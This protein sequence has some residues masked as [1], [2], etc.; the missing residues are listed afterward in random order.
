MTTPTTFY[1]SHN[2]VHKKGELEY[3]CFLDSYQFHGLPELVDKFENLYE[4]YKRETSTNSKNIIIENLIQVYSKIKRKIIL[5]RADVT[6]KTCNTQNYDSLDRLNDLTIFHK[7]GNEYVLYDNEMN[8]ALYLLHFPQNDYKSMTKLFGER[9][10]QKATS[11]V[12]A[13]NVQ[14][15]NTD[16]QNGEVYTEPIP[17]TQ[18]SLLS[19]FRN[20]FTRRATINPSTSPIEVEAKP[21]SYAGKKHKK[22][23]KSRRKSKR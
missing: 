5:V 14:P 20:R 3:Y 4:K 16:I 17:V 23:H 18:P 15:I 21:I 2:K 19:R 13:E 22:K 7:N 10:A 8:Y 11:T 12:T 6:S 1:L 9:F